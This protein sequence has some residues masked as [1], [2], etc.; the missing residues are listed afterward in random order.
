MIA[1]SGRCC[2]VC[3]MLSQWRKASCAGAH[4][5]STTHLHDSAVC[6][7]EPCWCLC[8]TMFVCFFF[9]C[10]EASGKISSP[11][12][13][14]KIRANAQKFE[15]QAEVGA[16][17]GCGPREGGGRGAGQQLLHRAHVRGRGG[18]VCTDLCVQG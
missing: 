9:C 11:G 14:A 5:G 15:F 12:F 18:A 4:A 16:L 7:A 2:T 8:C 6:V 10:S 13:Q 3:C 17:L 1:F